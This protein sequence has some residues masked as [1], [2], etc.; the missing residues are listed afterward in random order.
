MDLAAA[1]GFDLEAAMNSFE[2][3]RPGIETLQVSARSGTGFPSWIEQLRAR[4][5][6]KA[7]LPLAV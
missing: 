1:V 4:H 5:A 7:A 2:A 6:E 3:A